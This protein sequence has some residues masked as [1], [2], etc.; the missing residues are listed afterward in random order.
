MP[1]L[2]SPGT[3]ERHA[4]TT[5]NALET[6]YRDLPDEDGFES[7][8]RMVVPDGLSGLTA[9]DMCCRR[10][11][12]AFKLSDRV[13]ANGLVIGVDWRE[14]MITEARAAT[15]AA[16]QRN[17]YG[18]PNVEFRVGLPENLGH[19]VDASSVDVAFINSVLNLTCSPHDVLREI[20]TALKP[21]GLF[22]CQTVVA[23]DRVHA[24]AAEAESGTGQAGGERTVMTGAP[25]YRELLTW[26][27]AAG[28]DLDTLERIEEAP[29]CEGFTELVLHVRTARASA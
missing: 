4:V 24:A 9:L 6:W 5:R 15:P 22:V 18:A 7:R 10:G 21:G 2:G 26:L 14:G 3:T 1:P 16:M 12:G 25:A 8:C 28:F 27:N 29:V 20:A 19:V 17:G 11:K 13:G 23:D